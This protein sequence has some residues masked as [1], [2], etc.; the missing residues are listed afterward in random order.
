[1]LVVDEMYVDMDMTLTV[2]ASEYK[3]HRQEMPVPTAVSGQALAES[4][5]RQY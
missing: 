1:M 4:Y 2:D 3:T 5:S